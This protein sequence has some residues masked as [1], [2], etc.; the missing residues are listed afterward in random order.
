MKK[1]KV[2]NYDVIIDVTVKEIKQND[3]L[4]VSGFDDIGYGDAYFY[5]AKAAEDYSDTNKEVIVLSSYF[6]H[7]NLETFMNNV[8]LNIHHYK[9]KIN[10]SLYNS[11]KYK[12]IEKQFLIDLIENQTLVY[13]KFIDNSISDKVNFINSY[14][15]L[16]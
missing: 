8:Q 11:E 6:T 5:L 1:I 2:N 4:I 10:E 14:K 9:Q 3:L 15:A 13:Q 16:I 12:R 7:R